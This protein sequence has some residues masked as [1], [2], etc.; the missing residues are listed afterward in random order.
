MNI[1][2]PIKTQSTTQRVLLALREAIY[3]K[4]LLPGQR[5]TQ[6]DLA[7]QLN[8]SITPIREALMTL[9]MEQLVKIEPHKETIILGVNEKYI[10]DYYH[11]RTVLEGYLSEL[12]ARPGTDISPIEAAYQRMEEVVHS[13]QYDSYGAANADFHQAIYHVAGNLFISNLL[14]QISI[15]QS[16]AKTSSSRNYVLQSFQEHARIMDCI[17]VHDPEHAA[18]EMKAH[19]LRSMSDI[20]TYFSED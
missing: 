13:G 17:R 19:L 14:S 7:R 15:S 11:T 2:Q 6:N 9:E 3:T 16:A 4:K 18:E 8:V 10:R 20:L 5:I 1:L 12:V